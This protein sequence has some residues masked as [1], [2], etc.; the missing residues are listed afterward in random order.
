MTVV[1]CT[2]QHLIKSEDLNHHGTLYA[3]RASEWFV[4]AGFIAAAQ[5]LRPDMVYCRNVHGMTFQRPAHL[6]EIASFTS[7]AVL[8]G[9]TSL[10]CFIEMKIN[11]VEI[12]RG[13]ITFLNVDA[14]GRPQPHGLSLVADTPEDLA[15]QEEAR[16]L[17]K[18]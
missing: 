8:A 6:G 10:V 13:F 7:K 16:N 5:W 9:R 11:G 4:E 15:L 14:E 17:P 18:N 3:G 1:T 12:V 2:M